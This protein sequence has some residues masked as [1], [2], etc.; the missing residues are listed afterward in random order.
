MLGDRGDAG[1]QEA[2]GAE[3]AERASVWTRTGQVIRKVAGMPDYNGHIEHLRRCHPEQP[4]PS[5]RQFYEEFL[6]NRYGDQPTR[7]C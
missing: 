6:R 3:V 7:C 5:Q 4:I 1:K 2:R